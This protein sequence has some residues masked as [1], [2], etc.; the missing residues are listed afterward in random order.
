MTCLKRSRTAGG[1][2]AAPQKPARTALMSAP[3]SGTSST[4][5][6]DVGT[7]PTSVAPVLR[8]QAPEALHH[9]RVAQPAGRHDQQADAGHEGRSAP[10]KIVPPTWNS[11]SVAVSV[12]V[13]CMSPS[14]APPSAATSWLR[15]V[16]ATSFGAPVGA[17]GVE[18]RGH[19]VVA[20]GLAEHQAVVGLRHQRRHG[21]R[22]R[23][24]T[25]G[26]P[27]GA[28]RSTVSLGTC[29]RSASAFCQMSS[30]GCGPSATRMRAAT[31]S[32]S[33]AMCSAAAGS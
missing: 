16:C 2:E 3:P 20:A 22:A 19:V 10:Q 30:T 5:P 23:R 17:A 29:S 1:S 26:V 24:P 8:R 25:A 9:R 27:G 33:S 21:S 28:T 18:V 4:A 14:T 6:T 7:A 31:P 11:G 15:C 32:S 13:G 12:S